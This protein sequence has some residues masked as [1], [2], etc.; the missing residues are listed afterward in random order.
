MKTLLYDTLTRQVTFKTY[1][2]TVNMPNPSQSV[3]HSENTVQFPFECIIGIISLGTF[4]KCLFFCAESEKQGVYNEKDVYKVMKVAYISIT[5]DFDKDSADSVVNLFESLN[6]YYMTEPQEEHF[7]WNGEMLRNFKEWAVL[8]YENNKK[9]TTSSRNPFSLK[10]KESKPSNNLDQMI[11]G[12]LI[13]GY[14]ETQIK[15]DLDKVYKFS[16]F[17]KI[18]TKKIGT[19]LL[20]RG[21][22]ELGKVSFFV[23]TK[24]ITEV[25]GN[26]NEFTILRGSVPVFWSQDDPLK[27]HKI[28]IGSDIQ[29]ARE[30]F[31]AHFK[32]LE[33]GYGKIVVIDLLGTKKYE[34]LLSQLYED[35][36][37]EN[38]IDYIHFDLN[39]HAEDIES[40][41]CIFYRKIFDFIKN[42][43]QRHNGNEKD[44]DQDNH[45]QD[46][47]ILENLKSNYTSFINYNSNSSSS[48]SE[49]NAWDEEEEDISQITSEF[50]NLALQNKEDEFKNL[51]ITFR[52]NCM[53]C[54]DRTNIGQYI[55][56]GYFSNLNFQ[57]IKSMWVNNGNALSHMYTGSNSLKSELPARGKLSMIGRMSDFV[58]S[59]NRMIQNKFVDKDKQAIIDLILGKKSN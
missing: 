1:K 37:I 45:K 24:F 53:D 21:V 6:F 50:E 30:A 15:R 49:E 16:I 31:K 58:I 11:I 5:D 51:N 10:I 35:L 41:K 54:L 43:R 32:S 33:A 38:S 22:D 42:Y 8:P 48:E 4:C 55:I 17:S 25:S 36:C 12:Y 46:A 47:S 52:V 19:R 28:Q 3:I 26:K 27:P 7:L 9:V 13:C 18:S 2:G 39:K 40:I 20:S 57:V 34:R 44:I 56:F 14:F 59:A 29:R 23:E